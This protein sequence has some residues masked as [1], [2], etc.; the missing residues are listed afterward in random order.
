MTS[1]WWFL[2]GILAGHLFWALVWCVYWYKLTRDD[3]EVIEQA[4]RIMEASRERLRQ[5]MASR[6]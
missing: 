2:L 1:F 6:N 3:P 4:H 5:R